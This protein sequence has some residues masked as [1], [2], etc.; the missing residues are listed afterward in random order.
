MP[1]AGM[2]LTAFLPS[3]EI[4]IPAPLAAMTMTAYAP[5][6]SEEYLGSLGGVVRVRPALSGAITVRP[7]L[8]GQVSIN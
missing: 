8:S 4:V 7:A 5:T 6:F 1:M 3:V 2:T